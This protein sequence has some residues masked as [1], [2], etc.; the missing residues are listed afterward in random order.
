MTC[1]SITDDHICT[2]GGEEG[3]PPMEDPYNTGN[4]LMAVPPGGGD[5]DGDGGDDDDDDEEDDDEEEEEEIEE[6][7][8]GSDNETE[9]VVLDPDHVNEF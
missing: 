7:E 3:F 8:E 2:T 5:D 1:S 9:M 6:S 4:A